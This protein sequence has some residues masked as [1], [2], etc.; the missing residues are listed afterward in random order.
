MPATAW[1]WTVESRK[2]NAAPEHC[3]GNVTCGISPPGHP[4]QSWGN[5][6]FPKTCSSHLG[7]PGQLWGG[8]P[9]GKCMWVYPVG[10]F[11]LFLCVCA[12]PT[13][14]PGTGLYLPAMF[15]FVVFA[16]GGSLSCFWLF[17]S[18]IWKVSLTIFSGITQVIPTQRVVVG[19]SS[20]H[21]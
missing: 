19:V 11:Q 18:S 13:T 10:S 16:F 4:Q 6:H 5:A 12:D 17:S 20:E 7:H 2:E 9:S 8:Q 14:E 15:T 1:L 21:G 3:P